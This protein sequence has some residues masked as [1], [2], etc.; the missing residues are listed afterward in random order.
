M[1]GTGLFRQPLRLGK[2]VS[3]LIKVAAVKTRIPVYLVKI[4]R[5]ACCTRRKVEL[6]F[7]RGI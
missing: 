4:K 3:Q 1:Y 2:P 7:R 6:I 5:G